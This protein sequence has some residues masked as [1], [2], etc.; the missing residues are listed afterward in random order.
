MSEVVSATGGDLDDLVVRVLVS[1]KEFFTGIEKEGWALAR[2]IRPRAK[3]EFLGDQ[4]L[5][6]RPGMPV[7]VHAF[8]SFA[9]GHPLSE[10]D[11]EDATVT[12]SF[13]STKVKNTFHKNVDAF[14]LCCFNIII[15]NAL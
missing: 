11:L 2:I 6:F 13:S 14:C 4:P 12:I 3:I 15:M 1:I 9:D 8:A 5:I 7:T 10:E